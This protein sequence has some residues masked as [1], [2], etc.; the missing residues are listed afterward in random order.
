MRRRDYLSR[1]ESMFLRQVKF[2]INIMID[3]LQLNNFSVSLDN[4][5]GEVL[6]HTFFLPIFVI[7]IVFLYCQ[8]SII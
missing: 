8:S 7:F 2:K 4:L 1:S 3:M 5:I 6:I